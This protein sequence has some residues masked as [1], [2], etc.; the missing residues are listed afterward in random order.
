MTDTHETEPVCL[1]SALILTLTLSSITWGKQGCQCRKLSKRPSY[2]HRNESLRLEH[3]AALPARQ[4]QR[5]PVFR[6]SYAVSLFVFGLVLVS[7][8]SNWNITLA[9]PLNLSM[10]W[11]YIRRDSRA[12]WP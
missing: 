4:E 1:T 3:G 2:R 6:P 12:S 7:E 8:Y 11:P 5:K 9:L 10:S